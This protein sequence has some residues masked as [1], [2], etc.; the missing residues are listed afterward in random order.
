M[1]QR[2]N[3][4]KFKKVMKKNFSPKT[5][6]WQ[7]C[8][9]IDFISLCYTRPGNEESKKYVY[10]FDKHIPTVLCLCGLFGKF[11]KGV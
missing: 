10:S 4:F 3:A 6:I 11:D 5:S 7:F 8:S 1:F 9:I 2:F